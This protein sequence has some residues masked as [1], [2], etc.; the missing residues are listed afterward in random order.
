M[1]ARLPTTTKIGTPTQDNTHTGPHLYH[2]RVGCGEGRQQAR[3]AVT[4]G[5]GTRLLQRV[6]A[7]Q[8]PQPA[9]VLQRPCLWAGGGGI[10]RH[11][12][13]CS[14]LPT[15]TGCC[16]TNTL[17][18]PRLLP[19]KHSA[20]T[21]VTAQKPAGGLK[22]A[23]SHAHTRAQA[24]TTLSHRP[25]ATRPTLTT[26]TAQPLHNYCITTAPHHRPTAH[27]LQA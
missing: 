24:H 20:S 13:R 27:P 4:G 3:K 16:P 23:G 12:E 22:M 25:I 9:V 5:L 8:R 18:A 26:C 15:Y 19:N 10:R 21:P 2:R 7:Q 17:P 11:A 6:Q 1:P 14:D